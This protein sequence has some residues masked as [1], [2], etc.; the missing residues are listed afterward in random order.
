MTARHMNRSMQS[1]FLR[2]KSFREASIRCEI[3]ND[4]MQKAWMECCAKLDGMIA[5]S[6]KALAIVKSLTA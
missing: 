2:D 6:E 4:E 3:A 1:D 5:D